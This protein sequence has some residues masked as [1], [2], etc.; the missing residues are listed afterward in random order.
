M[1]L[2]RLV[3]GACGAALAALIF[4]AIASGDFWAEGKWLTTNPW[5]IVSLVDLYLGLVI[6]A[7]LIA[8]VERP[9]WAIFWIIPLP[10]LGNVWT[11]IWFLRRSATLFDRLI[12]KTR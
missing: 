10:F 3:L 5:G 11:V 8:L 2:V 1:V 7:V 4:W 9:K 6:S 12:A